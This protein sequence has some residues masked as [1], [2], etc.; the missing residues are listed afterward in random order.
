MKV[1]I[2]DKVT[3]RHPEEAY[4]SEYAGNPK[5]MFEPGMVGTVND[6]DCPFMRKKGVFACVDFEG[7]IDAGG[8]SNIWRVALPDSN[9][10]KV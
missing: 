3:C 10:K 4:Y 5:V 2:G 9:M 6:V 8:K 1:K 7:P